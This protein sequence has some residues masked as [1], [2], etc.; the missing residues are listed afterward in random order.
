MRKAIIDFILLAT[1]F[2]VQE[3]LQQFIRDNGKASTMCNRY[4]VKAVEASCD[5]KNVSRRLAKAVSCHWYGNICNLRTTIH[6][7]VSILKQHMTNCNKE[8]QRPGQR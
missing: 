2:E 1:L 3:R 4:W 8:M 5:V 7:N 6:E